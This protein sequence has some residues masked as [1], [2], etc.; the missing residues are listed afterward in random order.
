MRRPKESA[1]S[2]DRVVFVGAVHEAVP[3]LQVLLDA[4]VDLAG[5]FTA[6]IDQAASLS[7]Y[8]DL[9][10]L[11]AGSGVPVFRVKNLNATPC[12][13]R[14]RALRPDLLVVVGWSRLIGEELLQLPRR[15]CMGFHASLLPHNRGRAPVNWAIIRGEKTTG[16]TMMYLAAGADLGDIVTQR[17]IP[18]WPEDTCATIYAEV[19]AAGAEML[20]EELGRLLAGT[21]A[22]TPQGDADDDPLPKRTPA[23][24]VTDWDRPADAV[25]NWIR[26][27][28][29]P[30]PGAFSLLT[31]HKVMLWRSAVPGPDEP[32]GLAGTV[33]WLEGAGV[34]V[35]TRGGS[36]LITEAGD[37]AGY[38]EPAA[39]WFTR[40]GFVP[41][42]R[43]D[44]VDEATA[45][46]AMGLPAASTA[47]L[48][49]RP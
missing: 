21:A 35:G 25:H 42:S 32:V 9:E 33:M 19:A 27:Q 20:R 4:D 2:P 43:F 10:P 40:R 5:V 14:I 18:I 12:V 49:A 22:R 23:M 26:G 48:G 17:R 47:L 24:G 15:G 16:N 36:I 3:A 45:R 37:D 46:W 30:Y 29:R 28:T 13:E 6:P 1:G 41:G 31:G 38:P 39:A 44:D 7:G 8:V 34:R 11:A